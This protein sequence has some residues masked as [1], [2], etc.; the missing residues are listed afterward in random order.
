L[1]KIYQQFYM[2]MT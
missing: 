2:L 1:Q